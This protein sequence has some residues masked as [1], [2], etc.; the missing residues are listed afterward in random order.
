M[1]YMI[2]L[3]PMFITT[4]A[5]AKFQTEEVSVFGMISEHN[6]F[7]KTLSLKKK[8]KIKDYSLSNQ[9]KYYKYSEK[10][11]KKILVSDLKHRFK[12]TPRKSKLIVDSLFKSNKLIWGQD[13]L[14][15][16]ILCSYSQ[17]KIESDFRDHLLTVT[18]R[19]HSIGLGQIRIA[20]IKNDIK[21][22]LKNFKSK[23]PTIIKMKKEILALR[24]KRQY[25]RYFKD[26]KVNIFA[27]TFVHYIK[28]KYKKV[29]KSVDKAHVVLTK[30]AKK[31]GL[32][33]TLD[34][35]KNKKENVLILNIMTAYNGF[36]AV[37]NKKYSNKHLVALNNILSKINK[38]R[39]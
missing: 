5:S 7:A 29:N 38:K 15:E 14:I 34:F 32:K 26:I 11:I 20:T 12:R 39:A 33:E 18:K 19:E 27:Q 36:T 2:L 21:P 17:L 9:I 4:Y 24:T 13:Q 22:L 10:D 30:R 8:I 1:K 37:E 35:I 28:S 23:N 31:K 3:L 16:R 25:E 6:S